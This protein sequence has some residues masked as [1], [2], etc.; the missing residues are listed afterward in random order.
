MADGMRPSLEGRSSSARRWMGS[1]RGPWAPRDLLLLSLCPILFVAAAFGSERLQ[2]VGHVLPGVR[3]DSTDVSGFAPA[4]LDA[5]LAHTLQQARQHVVRVR[6]GNAV[7]RISGADL[8]VR[9]A[10]ETRAQVL[11]AGR[12]GNLLA[13]L[14]WR[15]DRW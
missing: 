12:S 10:P 9:N 15:V 3:L 4:V 13:Q 2:S 7:F 8:S 1:F 14:A 6:V 11:A 5:A